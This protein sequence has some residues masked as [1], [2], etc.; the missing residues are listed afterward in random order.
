MH[1]SSTFPSSATRFERNCC[2]RCL[3]FLQYCLFAQGVL[4][5]STL[6]SISSIKLVESG[7]LGQGFPSFVS[8]NQ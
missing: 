8:A 7:C 1:G 3:S 2:E 4:D 5:T 6:P